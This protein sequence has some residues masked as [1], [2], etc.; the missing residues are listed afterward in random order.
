MQDTILL[1]LYIHR[2]YV[3]KGIFNIGNIGKITSKSVLTLF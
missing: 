3:L 1:Y 2:N